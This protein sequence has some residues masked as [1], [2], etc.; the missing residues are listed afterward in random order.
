LRPYGAQEALPRILVQSFGRIP[1]SRVSFSLPPRD[2][3]R[4][5]QGY[6]LRVLIEP[7]L[8]MAY[9]RR[10]PRPLLRE[11]QAVEKPRGEVDRRS[12]LGSLGGWRRMW[13][14]LFRRHRSPKRNDMAQQKAKEFLIRAQASEQCLDAGIT[15]ILVQDSSRNI[16]QILE[17]GQPA[18]ISRPVVRLVNG[19]ETVQQNIRPGECI[20]AFENLSSVALNAP[21]SIKNRIRAQS[22]LPSVW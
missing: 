4:F 21:S 11:P 10:K 3:T 9:A 1:G 2:L 20:N 13:S 16:V 6:K 15:G 19:S 7:R 8:G 18:G 5:K 14:C 12:D 22:Q 17:K